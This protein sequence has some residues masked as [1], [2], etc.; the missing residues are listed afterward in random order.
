MRDAI[1]SVSVHQ[2]DR[3]YYIKMFVDEGAGNGDVVCNIYTDISS[4]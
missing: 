1:M 4:M 3:V 2:N